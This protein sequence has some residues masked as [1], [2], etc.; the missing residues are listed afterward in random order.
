LETPTTEEITTQEVTTTEDVTTTTEAPVD[1][2]ALIAQLRTEYADTIDSDTFV[3]TEDLTL[4][5]SIGSIEITWSSNNETYLEND[6][7]VHRPTYTEGNQTVILTASITDGTD[8]ESYMFFVTI[9]ALDKSDAER[10]EE[11]FVVVCA[12]PVKESWSSADVLVLLTTGQD[13]DDVS[14]TVVWTS[15]HPEYISTT[16][17]ITQ[18]ADE[19]VEVTLTATIT[20]ADVEYTK[21]VVFTVAKLASGTPVSTIAEG[22]ALGADAYVEFQGMTVCAKFAEGQFFFTDGVDIMYVYTTLLSVEVGQVYDITGV[23][24]WYYNA[25]ELTGSAT[26]P[27]KVVASGAAVSEL[28]PT[29][30]TVSEAIADLDVPSATTP[31]YYHMVTVTG[32]VY[33][34]AALGTYGTF[35]VPT[36]YDVNTPLDTTVTDAIM[37]YYKSDISVISALAGQTITVDLMMYGWRT[38]KLVWY[39]NFW[40]TAE[41]V[42]INIVDDAEAVATALAAVTLPTSIIEGTTLTLPAE[43]Y[44]VTLT[45]ASDNEAIINSTT[46]VVDVSTLTTQETVTIT[47][48]ATRGTATDTK[49]IVIKV[50]ELPISTILEVYDDVALP[51]ASLIRIQG[52]ITAQTKNSGFWIQDT[53][54][55]LNIYIYDSAQQAQ[56]AALVGQEVILIGE[57]DIYNGLYEIKNITDITVVNPA[58]TPITP[59]SMTG[60]VLDATN[61]AAY[62]GQLISFEGYV[63]KATITAA[64]GTSFNFTLINLSNG[65]EIAVRVESTLPDYAAVYAE[66][67]SYVTG[68]AIDVSG[69]I[70]SWYNGPQLAVV[71]ADNFAAGT[72]DATDADLL[73][74]DVAKFPTD[75]TWTADYTL[76]TR[77]FSTVTAVISTELQPY[78]T[79]DITANGK[80]LV[81]VPVGSD[82]T[83]TITFT[84]TRNLETTDV[85]VNVTLTAI[86]EQAALDADAALIPVTLTMENNYELP[87]AVYGSTFTV[88]GI[89][90]DAAT[91]L[92]YTLSPGTIIVLSRPAGADATG[93]ITVEVTLGTATP[94]TINID[95]TV[96]QSVT[97]TLDLFFSEYSE[98]NVGNNKWL[99]IYNPTGAE[100][101]LTAYTVVLYSNGSLTPTKTYVFT[102]TLAAGEVFVIINGEVTVAEVIAAADDSVLYADLDAVCIFNG[103]DTLVLYHGTEVVD[104]IGQ[105]GQAADFAKDVT[106]VRNPEINF[107]DTNPYD[108]FD[109]N[110]EWTVYPT[111]DGT[112]VGSHD[113]VIQ[114]SDLFFSEY[115]EGNVGNNKWIEIFNGTG[116]EVDLTAY[117]VVLYS[118]GATTPTKTYTFT[119]TLA[120]GDVF[121]IINGE[122]T[123]AEVIAAADDSVLYA[124]LDAVCIFNGNDTLVLYHGTEVVDVIGQL[125]QAAD[126]AK[127]VTLVRMP[128]I[129]KG[130]T[131]PYDAFDYTVEWDV[132]PTQDGTHVGAHTTDYSA[133]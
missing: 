122:V 52:I 25:P 94:A 41:D 130:D 56:L 84:V 99:E 42:E 115:S 113:M 2:E 62:K 83:G 80:L 1:L 105:L 53:T 106:L 92:N 110:V 75:V 4:L 58:P 10:A 8:T 51:D 9:Q 60:I 71:N 127:D 97:Q 13:D 95:V 15:S 114:V 54:A 7:T 89:T 85:V 112:H 123:V 100:V 30:V 107:G 6:G 36:G 91:Y 119:G 111:Q 69:I 82:V 46:G 57:K 17:V 64:S 101:D 48:T 70:L 76:P 102:G 132:Y 19:N 72:T 98:G 125:G 40:G 38:D 34:D 96:A 87:D 5:G 14:Y 120:T 39:A 12:F 35:L 129:F 50:G 66:L 28:T 93:V 55:G 47:V 108:T 117:T 63:L 65:N 116:A 73:A 33:Y 118:N 67:T 78:V 45:Y 126:F 103:N 21:D 37:I 104:V 18:P 121:V 26:Q 90:G 74:F 31:F 22:I 124:D 128:T 20:I 3:A 68:S 77:T 44:G 32:T 79:D 11:V 16:G 59:T 49:T 29:A 23:F 131:N 27:L 43:L 24:V 133:Y 88:T 86:T 109:Y 61:L 81:T